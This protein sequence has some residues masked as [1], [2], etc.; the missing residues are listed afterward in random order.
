VKIH[1]WAPE[2]AQGGGGIETYS[3]DVLRALTERFGA[4]SISVIT[5]HDTFRQLRKRWG[6][7]YRGHGTGNIPLRFRTPVFAGA[8][9]IQALL[10]RPDLIIS[11]HVNF[12]PAAAWLKKTIGSRYLLFLYGIDVW[13]L[14]E[15]SRKRAILSADMHIAISSYTAKRMEREQGL[16]SSHVRVLRC[17][18][19]ASLFAIGPKPKYL[20]D[21]YGLTS[22]L[23]V[24]LTVGR[25]HAAEAYK[26]HDRILRILSE[27]RSQ[28]SESNDRQ[29][30]SDLRLPTS[31]LRYVIVGDGDDRPRLEMLAA[32]LGVREA[33]VF[34][35]KVPAVELND[36]YN[37]C[38]LFAMPSTGE[39]FGIVFLEA[40]ACGKPVLG[41]N[42]DASRDALLDG[43][44]GILVDPD[45]PN[46]LRSAIV[47]ILLKK[48][49]HPLIYKPQALRAKVIKHFG[50]EK[51]QETLTR[52]VGEFFAGSH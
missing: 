29:S 20:L 51:F 15:L 48:H 8:I 22:D 28:L 5:K 32:D 37:L 43:E 30:A 4:S 21:R 24:I 11:M 41:G 40:L 49:P 9:A 10:E 31:D 52:Y 50:Y 23:P 7:V 6:T 45:D 14:E 26:G 36:H 18:V 27:V 1:L 2:L 25:L 3:T 16:P 42:K 13:G 38:D 39:G 34:A 46:E 19:D 35:G 12:G 33:V 44:L 17:I 47:S